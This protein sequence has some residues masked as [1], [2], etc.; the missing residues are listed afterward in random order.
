MSDAATPAARL[1]VLEREHPEW[2]PWTA[3]LRLVAREI[4]DPTWDR[5]AEASSISASHTGPPTPLLAGAVLR[6]DPPAV[7]RWV[8]RLTATRSTALDPLA[9]VEAALAGDHDRIKGI[10]AGAGLDPAALAAIAPLAA[11]PLLHACRRTCQDRLPPAWDRGYCPLCGGWPVIAEA[12]GLERERRLDCG[13]CGTDWRVEWLRCP[14]CGN[15]DHTSLGSLVPGSS[16]DRQRVET[17]RRCRGYVKTLATLT[18]LSP[19]DLMLEDLATVHLDVAAIEHD[20]RRPPG[21]GHPVATRLV[22]RE[23]VTGRLGRSLASWFA[24]R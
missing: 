11:V 5:C 10:A 14:Y 4:D 17:C 24:A 15:R 1:H 23:R 2:S 9:M 3:R 20:Y 18:A 12:R 19:A 7:A 16:P 21:L 13:R 22:P 8:T 6:V